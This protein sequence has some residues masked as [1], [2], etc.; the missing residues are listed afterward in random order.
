MFRL[1]WFASALALA[2]LGAFATGLPVTLNDFNC[3]FNSAAYCKAVAGAGK[4]LDPAASPWVGV[5]G[6]PA[7]LGASVVHFSALDQSACV[8]ARPSMCQS[9]FR[10]HAV[11]PLSADPSFE[12]LQDSRC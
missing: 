4:A 3:A 5:T 7:A 1:R 2:A 11:L 8:A 6:E 12:G 9:S 10:P